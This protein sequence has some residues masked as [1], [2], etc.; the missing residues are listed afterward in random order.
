MVYLIGAGPGDTGLITVK[1]LEIL[2]QA[3]VILYDHLIG[4]ELLSHAKDDAEKISVG[5]FASNHTLPQESINDLIIQK[6]KEGKLVAR[7]KG[8]DC[9]LFGRGGEEAEACHEAGIPYEVVPGITSA[10]AAPCYAGIPP[11]HRDCTSNIAVVTGHRKKGD[12]RPIDIP[13]AGTVIFLMSVGNI[14]N[15]IGSLLD[16]GWDADTKIAAVEHGTCYDQR[17][18]KGT[19]DNFL[20]VI[21][22]NPLRTPAIFIVGKVVELAEK[23]D[24]FTKKPKI[25]HLGNHPDRYAHLGTIVHRQIIRCI[26]SEND[27][28]TDAYFKSPPKHNWIV[29]TSG[30]GIQFFFKKLY[31]AG[32]D[33]RIF[34]NTKFA[35]IGKASGKRLL[36]FGIKAD[37]TA[38]TESSK[39]LLAAFSDIDIN[40]LSILLPQAEISSTELA[41]GLTDRGAA[42]DKLTVYKTVETEIDDVDLDYID[43]ILFTSGS[44]VRAFVNKFGS[45]PDHIEALCL[46][47]PT[48]TIAKQNNIDAK[49]IK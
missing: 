26:E 10:L 37:L 12:T 1:G 17:V 21:K 38:A 44:T 9:Y 11:T 48:Q 6:A 15:I 35:V 8:G 19:L 20:D 16:A 13:K 43:Q 7:L 49:I 39:G 24:W 29:F 22:D 2:S 5:K 46:G 31:A 40:R 33:A 14:K 34:A 25:L 23:L 47:T 42:I 4:H 30:N 3:D 27:D 28:Q 45:V 18:I 41:D 36:E 32:F